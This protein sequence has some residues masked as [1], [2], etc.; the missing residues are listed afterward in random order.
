MKK[1]A[2]LSL[3]ILLVISLLT[4]CTYEK[5]QIVKY[6]YESVEDFPV[7]LPYKDVTVTATA[8]FSQ[9]TLNDGEHTL[10]MIINVDCSGLT[11]EDFMDFLNQYCSISA[12]EYLNEE[13]DELKKLCTLYYSDTYAVDYVFMT[14]MPYTRNEPYE[15][16]EVRVVFTLA[17]TNLPELVERLNVSVNTL[18][19][20][21]LPD[22]DDVIQEPLKS[23]INEQLDK[24]MER[25]SELFG[26]VG[27]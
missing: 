3:C 25:D 26:S 18:C 7:L 10:Y 15:G 11:E 9:I 14:S 8:S 22:S 17:K 19:P 23:Y 4:A 21:E 16:S 6:D 12:Y 2:E 5:E 24:Q 27:N 1:S 20:N 13:L